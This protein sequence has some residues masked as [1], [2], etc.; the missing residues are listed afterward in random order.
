MM[1]SWAVSA[2][3]GWL[4]FTKPAIGVVIQ[5]RDEDRSVH[6]VECIKCLWDRSPEPLKE[7]W[8]LKR[9]LFQQP[10][11]KLE[12][13]NGSWCVGLTGDPQ[14]IRA[15]HPSI[16]VLDE[17]AHIENGDANYNIAMATRCI[18]LIVLS[19]AWPGWFREATEFATPCEWPDYSTKTPLF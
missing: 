17:G 9:P 11:N 3:C 4:M 10:Y 15:W 8:K 14:K 12:V 5:S 1:A 16:A 13:A 19:S 18:Q 7:R 6:D 2:W